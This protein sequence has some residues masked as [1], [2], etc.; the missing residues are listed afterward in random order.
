M[1]EI[2]GLLSSEFYPRGSLY[3]LLRAPVP[4]SDEVQ[5]QIIIGIARGMLHLHKESVVH[6]D[7]AARNVLVSPRVSFFESQSCNL[8]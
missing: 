4:I 2:M 3:A 8:F 5:Q 7:L 6:R 1:K